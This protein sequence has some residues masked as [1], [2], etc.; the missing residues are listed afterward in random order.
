M[1]ISRRQF[2]RGLVG[3]SDDRQREQLKRTLE[4]E[5]YVRTNL[6]PYDFALTGDQSAEVLAAAIGGVDIDGNGDLLTYENRMRLREIVDTK[7][8]VWREEYLQAEDVRRDASF[9]EEF[10]HEATAEE[11]E[12]LGT[13]LQM[14]YPADLH[15]EVDRQIRVWLSGLPNAFLAKSTHE[16]L[17]ELVF[18]QIRSW[19]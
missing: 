3:Q 4:V 7:V 13:F 15:Q 6:L 19:C 5:S 10:F 12:R 8:Q 1:P 18:S 9:V 17:R 16:E 11:L 14:P 2:F